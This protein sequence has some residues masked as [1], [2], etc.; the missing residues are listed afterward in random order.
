LRSRI[1]AEPISTF[2]SSSISI[3]DSAAPQTGFTM[4]PGTALAIAGVAIAL[5]S[6]LET[7]LHGFDRFTAGRKQAETSKRILVMLDIHKLRLLCWGRSLGL[8]NEL[9]RPMNQLLNDPTY[10]VPI[11]NTLRLLNSLFTDG[12]ELESRY[13]VKEQPYNPNQIDEPQSVFSETYDRY[14]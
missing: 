4:D 2:P 7:C 6:L 11:E 8:T 3:L 1:V 14:M 9:G 5:L 12:K 13:G 10:R